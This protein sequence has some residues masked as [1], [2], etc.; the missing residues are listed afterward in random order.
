MSFPVVNLPA[1]VGGVSL[2]ERVCLCKHFVLIICLP[3]FTCA[4]VVVCHDFCIDILVPNILNVPVTF[5]ASFV[6]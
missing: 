4:D 2:T 1:I 3:N 6:Y 5:S